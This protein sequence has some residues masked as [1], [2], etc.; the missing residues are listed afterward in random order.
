MGHKIQL[1]WFVRNKSTIEVSHQERL[2]NIIL[3]DT[4]IKEHNIV[5]KI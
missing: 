3:Q 1:K 2:T 4:G 5:H